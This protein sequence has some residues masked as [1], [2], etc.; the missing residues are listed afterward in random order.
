LELISRIAWVGVFIHAGVLLFTLYEPLLE[1]A[2]ALL[3][4]T[5]AVAGF[6]MHPRRDVFYVRTSVRLIDVDRNQ[7]L[8]HDFL[9]IR[10][11]VVR[12]FVF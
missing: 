4:V 12:L 3:I 2:I 1:G 11:E 5:A 9:A 10:V 7:T 8:E 6:L